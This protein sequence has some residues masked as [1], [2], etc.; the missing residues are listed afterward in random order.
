MVVVTSEQEAGEAVM[1]SGKSSTRRCYH[2]QMNSRRGD[3]SKLLDWHRTLIG[4]QSGQGEPIK[5]VS[6]IGLKKTVMRSLKSPLK[7]LYSSYYERSKE[8]K[9]PH[10][11][12][13]REVLELMNNRVS[14]KLHYFN[15]E[16]HWISQFWLFHQF[17]P[18][19]TRKPFLKK[20]ITRK[21][22]N[23]DPK[24]SFCSP[25]LTSDSAYLCSQIWICNTWYL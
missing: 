12:L 2:I 20:M 1:D 25:V 17:Q 22:K 23:T 9:E 10:R 24:V 5:W 4:L 6:G 15:C 7:L 11:I 13:E 8:A 14:T 21:E 18:K 3:I 16:V 19:D